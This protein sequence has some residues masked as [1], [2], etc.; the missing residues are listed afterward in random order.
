MYHKLVTLKLFDVYAVN[1]KP[2]RKN[3]INA[4]FLMKTVKSKD[5]DVKNITHFYDLLALTV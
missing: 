1:L 3:W 2:E 5:V 4:F